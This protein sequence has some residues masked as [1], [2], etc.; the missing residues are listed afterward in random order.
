MTKLQGHIIEQMRARIEALEAEA[1]VY[2][3]QYEHVWKDRQEAFKEIKA[4]Q[5]TN[6]QQTSRIE[7]LLSTVE[8]LSNTIHRLKRE[9]VEDGKTIEAAEQAYDLQ[10]TTNVLLANELEEVKRLTRV[11]TED[12]AQADRDRKVLKQIWQE[13]EAAYTAERL[14]NADLQTAFN[15]QKEIARR[16]AAR[17]DQAIRNLEAIGWEFAVANFVPTEPEG[18][19]DRS[20]AE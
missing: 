9:A 19:D 13:A 1:A 18:S 11:Q 17:A 16:H 14:K 12:L 6:A 10:I 20:E 8:S 2:H 4:L 15:L 7:N 5:T 3:K